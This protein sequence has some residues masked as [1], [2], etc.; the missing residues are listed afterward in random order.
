MSTAA[1]L[2]ATRQA[3]ATL[4]EKVDGVTKVYAYEPRDVPIGNQPSAS[5]WLDRIQRG[6]AEEAERRLGAD[7]YLCDWI[8]R[9]QWEIADPQ[10]AQELFELIGVNLRAVFDGEP[11]LDPNGVGVVDVSAIGEIRAL[12][13]LDRPIPM[14]MAEA[15]LQTL[16][17]I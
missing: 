1:K 14:F 13:D 5:V 3:I 4:L 12:L 16:T 6:G 15:T 2:A 10:R 8:I 11:L 9:V 17:I 7:D